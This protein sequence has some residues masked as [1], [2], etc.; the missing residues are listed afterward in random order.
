M[1]LIHFFFIQIILLE[2]IHIFIVESSLLLVLNHHPVD[3]LAVCSS[4]VVVFSLNVIQ[5]LIKFLMVIYLGLLLLFI[6]LLVFV[7]FFHFFLKFDVNS[8]YFLI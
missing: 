3:V 8:I 5:V 1:L 6:N 7:Y 2:V 4:P